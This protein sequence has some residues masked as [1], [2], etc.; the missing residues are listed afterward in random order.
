VLVDYHS[1]VLLLSLSIVDLQFNISFDSDQDGYYQEENIGDLW[2][3]VSYI[4]PC[5]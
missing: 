3:C 2:M 5:F 4:V 1:V